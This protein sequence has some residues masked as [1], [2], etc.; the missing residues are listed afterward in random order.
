ML[1][2]YHAF[3]EKPFPRNHSFI[4]RVLDGI[5]F[6]QFFLREGKRHAI[7]VDEDLI[8]SPVEGKIVELQPLSAERPV[9]GKNLLGKPG[10]YTF[11]ELVHGSEMGK[12]FEGGL[13]VNFYLSPFNLHYIISPMNLTI[14][15][16][17]YHPHFCMPI[18][19][20]KSGEVKN[21]RLVLYAE[22]DN[23]LPVI[24]LFIGSFMVAGLECLAREEDRFERGDLLG[25]FKLGSTVMLLFPK[26]SIEPLVSP[27]TKM[28]LG[29]PFARLR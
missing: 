16:M 27:N 20:M 25:G 15:K 7:V 11:R 12:E 23:G 10:F 24:L 8:V 4:E 17:M 29:E 2:P 13:C 19:F 14:R 21:E 5:G 3:K 6:N 1:K 9:K 26:D 18:L 28:L 22:T